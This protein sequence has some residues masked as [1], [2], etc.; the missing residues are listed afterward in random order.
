MKNSVFLGC[1]G[2]ESGIIKLQ[3]KIYVR[4][5]TVMRNCEC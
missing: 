5:P 1:R 4:N 2:I 3:N